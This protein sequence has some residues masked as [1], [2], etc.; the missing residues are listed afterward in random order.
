MQEDHLQVLATRAHTKK[1][2]KIRLL[3]KGKRSRTTQNMGQISTLAEIRSGRGAGEIGL[4]G[5][6]ALGGELSARKVGKGGE[7]E[8]GFMG[9]II[10]SSRLKN[11]CWNFGLHLSTTVSSMRGRSIEGSPFHD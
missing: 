1:S 11:R 4:P 3:D 7:G 2:M 8:R 6:E 10:L 5:G 9:E